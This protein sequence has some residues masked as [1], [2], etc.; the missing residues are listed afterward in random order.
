M[1]ALDLRSA[2]VSCECWLFSAGVT[3]SRLS[4]RLLAGL[5]SLWFTCVCFSEGG[6][7]R[8]ASATR[9]WTRRWLL[10]LML[11]VR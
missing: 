8:N 4:A 7:G 11:A 10:P 6:G 5:P 3:H 1:G 2:L 9:R